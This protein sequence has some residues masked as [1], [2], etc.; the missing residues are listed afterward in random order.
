MRLLCMYGASKEA[1]DQKLQ[2]D[3]CGFSSKLSESHK[4]SMAA[5]KLICL[6][7]HTIATKLC[8]KKFVILTAALHSQCHIL[9]GEPI[10]SKQKM[11]C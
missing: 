10:G 4:Q 1:P 2:V 6:K 7:Y 3:V 8:Q 11:V 5:W 9:F